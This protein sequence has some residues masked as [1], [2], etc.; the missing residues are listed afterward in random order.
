MGFEDRVFAIPLEPR[1]H[2][3]FD[4]HDT[5]PG[6]WDK[7]SSL[8]WCFICVQSTCRSRETGTGRI[9]WVLHHTVWLGYYCIIVMFQAFSTFPWKQ[10][11]DLQLIRLSDALKAMNDLMGEFSSRGNAYAVVSTFCLPVWRTARLLMH[12]K[13]NWH[14]GI[15]R[16][17]IVL[18]WNIQG[19]MFRIYSLVVTLLFYKAA[20]VRARVRVYVFMCVHGACVAACVASSYERKRA[21]A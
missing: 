9:F 18:H 16:M 21:L 17:L 3:S 13:E 2:G 11:W 4:S 20:C 12:R 7:E 10:C 5:P 6:R 14:S 19:E 15:K 8:S 1:L